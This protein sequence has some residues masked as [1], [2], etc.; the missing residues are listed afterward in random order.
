MS[1]VLARSPLEPMSM[2]GAAGGPKRRS[3]RL[4]NDA[5]EEN[6]L[7]VK[8]SKGN[9]NGA[10]TTTVSTKE[11]DGDAGVASKKKRKGEIFARIPE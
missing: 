9:V 4:S 7:P 10:Q 5:A 6:E 2:N 8:K 11:S 3:A 1:M